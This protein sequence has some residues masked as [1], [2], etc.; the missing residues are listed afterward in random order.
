M[1]CIQ[2]GRR[3]E[4]TTGR[5]TKCSKKVYI[6]KFLLYTMYNSLIYS[7]F[8][9]IFLFSISFSSNNLPFTQ[10]ISPIYPLHTLPTRAFGEEASEFPEPFRFIAFISNEEKSPHSLICSLSGTHT[11]TYSISEFIRN[12]PGQRHS[13]ELRTT[14]EDRQYQLARI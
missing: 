11:H 14:D 10:S 5:R 7:V 2:K 3:E 9:R 13:V 6:L 8:V 4:W 1:G 12:A